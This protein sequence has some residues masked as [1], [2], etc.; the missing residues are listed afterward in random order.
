MRIRQPRTNRRGVPHL[1]GL[2]GCAR[3]VREQDYECAASRRIGDV[4]EG[5]TP[6][7]PR[8]RR[9]G[10]PSEN[11]PSIGGG[12]IVFAPDHFRLA[13]FRQLGS[14]IY[15]MRPSKRAVEILPG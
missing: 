15:K 1:T 7:Y 6:I 11:K 8:A 10:L 9:F 2:E 4:G 13:R 14:I 12:P 3:H 5:R